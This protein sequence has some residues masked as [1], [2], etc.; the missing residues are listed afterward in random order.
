[1]NGY[2][3]DR[4]LTQDPDM[5]VVSSPASYAGATVVASVENDSVMCNYLTVAG[6]K[7]PFSDVGTLAVTELSGAPLT[8]VMVPA[9]G[10]ASGYEGLDV[11]GKV[12]V[13]SRGE[14]PFT[15]K[16]QNAFDAGAVALL[17]YDNVEG[18]LVNMQDAGVLPSAFVSKASGEILAANAE[19]G[20]GTL[21]IMPAGE[22]IVTPSAISGTMSDFSSWGVTPR[23]A[24]DARRH[25]SRRQHLLHPHRRSLRHL[26]R[27][28]HGLSP[29]RRYE[30]PGAGV[31]QGSV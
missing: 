10:D 16:Q 12:A 9:Y 24:A 31:P 27:H 20:Q 17:V 13:V 21:E 1:M 19:N 11:S 15:D 6:E 29:H 5:G 23:S 4:N 3:T 2:R 28:L 26:E 7:I 22:R 8:Y 18:D 14:L 25:R 30:R